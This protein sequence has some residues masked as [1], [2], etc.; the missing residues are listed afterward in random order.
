MPEI[1]RQLGVAY[2]LEGSVE[3]RGDAVRINVQLVKAA[4]DSHVWADTFDRELTDIFS[5]ESEV[6]KAIADELRA[7]LTGEK[8]KSFELSPRKIPEAYD[9]Y[10]RGLAYT[11][12]AGNNS[13]N[14]LGAQKYFR[15]AVR[16]DPKFC[17][18][19]G[20]PLLY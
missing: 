5:V 17:P 2:V 16:L 1:A 8:S 15:D 11:L 4:S 10:L 3:K 6:A 13:A 14:A 20:A 9:A 12:K 19:M 7:Q 18:G